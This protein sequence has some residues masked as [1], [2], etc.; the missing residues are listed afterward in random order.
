MD[1][2]DDAIKGLSKKEVQKCLVSF[3][4][5]MGKFQTWHKLKKVLATLGADALHMLK[6]AQDAKRAWKMVQRNELRK[7]RLEQF[8]DQH[9][10]RWALESD[11]F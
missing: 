3:K 2:I 4:L 6:A 8:G 5:C 1:T 10:V 11:V 7:R 9:R